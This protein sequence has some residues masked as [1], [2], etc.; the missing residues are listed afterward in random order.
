MRK[1]LTLHKTQ[2]IWMDSSFIFVHH[3]EVTVHR[4]VCGIRYCIFLLLC[5]WIWNCSDYLVSQCIYRQY[6]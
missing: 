6:A 3:L 5:D 4:C 2:L 1:N